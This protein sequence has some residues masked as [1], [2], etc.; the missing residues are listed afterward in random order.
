MANVASQGNGEAVER[1][2]P[3]PTR[4]EKRNSKK[5][6]T[7]RP[8]EVIDSF[9]IAKVARVDSTA[10]EPPEVSLPSTPEEWQEAFEEPALSIFE[11]EES[12]VDVQGPSSMIFFPSEKKPLTRSVN[13]PPWEKY[14]VTVDDKTLVI[15][16]KINAVWGKTQWADLGMGHYLIE[17]LG[18]P[19]Q[20]LSYLRHELTIEGSGM[21]DEV[22]SFLKTERYHSVTIKPPPNAKSFQIDEY[23]ELI[24]VTY[25]LKLAM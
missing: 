20:K 9:R 23:L 19:G 22:I 4:P 16:P 21:N 24:L 5:K 17:Y 14:T 10:N 3:P 13:T 2:I 15:I 18:V 8:V 25:H 12:V 7:P 11:E 6:K 1:E